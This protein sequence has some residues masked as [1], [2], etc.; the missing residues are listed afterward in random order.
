MLYKLKIIL[1][2]YILFFRRFEN[3]IK[4]IKYIIGLI[5]ILNFKYLVIIS[6]LSRRKYY[7][8][9]YFIIFILNII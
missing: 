3:I 1:N 5:L 6:I 8:D 4:Y 9:L 2:K 7:E